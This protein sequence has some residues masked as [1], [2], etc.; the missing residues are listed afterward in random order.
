MNRKDAL[1]MIQAAKSA[2]VQWRARAQ[3]LVAGIPMEKGQVPI[4]YTDCKFGKWYYGVGQQLLVL[5]SYRAIEE[6][7]EQLHLVYMEIFN[8]LFG[9]DGRPAMKK[10]FG[11][12]RKHRSENIA[13]ARDLVPQLV[14]ISETLLAEM[15]I[16]EGQLRRM[17][18]DDLAD[19]IKH[20]FQ[21]V[22]TGLGQNLYEHRAH[23]H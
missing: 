17:S 5:E 14:S 11:S 13:K 4:T 3:A 7:H 9:D 12:E 10:L 19:L 20:D 1:A 2:H 6:P 18:D 22:W 16:L 15:G 8:H 23:T 21:P